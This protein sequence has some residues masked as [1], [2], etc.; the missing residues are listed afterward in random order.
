M[1][2]KDKKKFSPNKTGIPVASSYHFYALDQV[3]EWAS[4]AL[5]PEKI[6]KRE[7]KKAKERLK[8]EEKGKLVVQ[9]D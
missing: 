1:A 8:L 7:I 9:I 4:S 3:V 5:D 6:E 2:K